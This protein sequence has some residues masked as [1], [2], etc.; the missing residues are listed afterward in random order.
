MARILAHPTTLARLAWPYTLRIAG[1]VFL[2]LMVQGH[3]P[4]VFALPAGLGDIATGWPR[5]SSPA[6]WPG[7]LAMPAAAGRC[8]STCWAFWIWS[9]P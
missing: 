7:I 2:I 4:A 1:V 5:R 8:G 6:G 9:W 3:L